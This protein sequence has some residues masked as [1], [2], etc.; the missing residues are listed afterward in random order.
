MYNFSRYIEWPSSY[1]KGEFVIGVVGESPLYKE[2]VNMART[3]KTGNQSFSIKKYA[4]VE[5]I[6]KCHI[7]FVPYKKS[8][9]VSSVAK[10][11][12]GSSALV[13]AEKAG[14]SAKG[15]GINFVVKDNRTKFEMNKKALEKRGLKISYKLETLAILVN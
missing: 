3:K 8:S 7:V 5:Q 1:K 4:S 11:V 13:I 6:G 10:K 15:A 14:L 9:L 2:L 12:K